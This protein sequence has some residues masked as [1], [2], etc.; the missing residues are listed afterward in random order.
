MSSSPPSV[1]GVS[2]SSGTSAAG[3]GTETATVDMMSGAAGGVAEGEAGGGAFTDIA[4]DGSVGVLVTINPVLRPCKMPCS[5]PLQ[6][7]YGTG[8]MKVSNRLAHDL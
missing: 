7:F 4:V 1:A 5:G 6:C 8:T 3:G 2:C